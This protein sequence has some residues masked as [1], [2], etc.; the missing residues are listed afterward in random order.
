MWIYHKDACSIRWQWETVNEKNGLF[1]VLNWA[2]SSRLFFSIEYLLARANDFY[3]N[4]MVTREVAV[5]VC[6][7]HL[8]QVPS[9]V[10]LHQTRTLAFISRPPDEQGRQFWKGCCFFFCQQLRRVAEQDVVWL[11]NNAVLLG[12]ANNNSLL[13]LRLS[14]SI[15][16]SIQLTCGLKIGLRLCAS[17]C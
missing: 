7:N 4:M 2:K 3:S 9:R 5:P 6:W 11:A 1:A 16:F 17:M 15:G 12:C 14:L 13:L 8:S 10:L